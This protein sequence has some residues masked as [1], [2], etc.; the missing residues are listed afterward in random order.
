[1]VAADVKPP[2]RHETHCRIMWK[3]TRVRET[4][5]KPQPRGRWCSVIKCPTSCADSPCY[6]IWPIA[7]QISLKRCLAKKVAHAL[8][9]LST[10]SSVHQAIKFAHPPHHANVYTNPHEGRSHDSMRITCTKLNGTQ[11]WTFRTPEHVLC[12]SAGPSH[13]SSVGLNGH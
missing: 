7:E 10:E 6:R 5:Q 11:D 12:V 2:E 4:T 3:V 8:A 9:L 13:A 1:M